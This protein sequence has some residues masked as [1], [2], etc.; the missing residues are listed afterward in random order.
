MSV[1]KR[2]ELIAKVERMMAYLSY[3]WDND[4]EWLGYFKAYREQ[5]QNDVDPNIQDKI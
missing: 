1:D 5:T 4:K 2:K 3:E